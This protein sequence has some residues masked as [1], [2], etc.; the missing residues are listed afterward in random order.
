LICRLRRFDHVTDA[1]VS[2]HWLHVME[3]V[4]YK[5]AVLTFKVMH[6][7][8]PSISDLL[9]MSPI[10]LVDSLFVLLA[11]TAWWCHRLNC[12]PLALELSR[13]PVLASGIVCQQTLHRHRRFRPTTINL[14]IPTIISSSHRLKICTP[15]VYLVVT[16]T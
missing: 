2:L 1:L 6:G 14:S 13:W 8:A 4:V 12:Q 10:C 16:F 3:H 15:S 9:F 5:I 11:L 7:I